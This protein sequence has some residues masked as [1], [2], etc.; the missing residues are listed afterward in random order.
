[1]NHSMIERISDIGIV[2]VVK[3]SDPNDSIPLAKALYEGGLDVAEITFRTA[4]APQAIKEIREALPDMCIG[5]GTISSIEQAEA[6]FQAGASFLVTPGW[7]E[8]VVRWC[9]D[10]ELTVIPGVSSASEIETALSYGCSILKFFPAQ[11]SGGAQKLKDLYGPY[12]QVK[13]LPTGGINESNLHDYLSLPNVL[14]VGGSFMLANEDIQA[15]DWEKVCN[16]TKQA[17]QTMLGYELIHIGINHES[18]AEAK[19]STDT[20]CSLFGFPCYHKPK[21]YFAGRGFELLHQKGPGKHGHIAIYT[22]YPKRAMYHLSKQGIS[23]VQDSIT[24]NKHTNQIN[25]VYLDMDLAGFGIHLIHPDVK[26]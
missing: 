13:F 1:M 7:N 20:L 17:V 22:P 25:F 24:R 18:Q 6:A 11:S 19:K 16:K 3:I 23:F 4:Y 15:K 8:P 21:S 26:M 2:P 9:A 14:A 5:A 10:H 12:A